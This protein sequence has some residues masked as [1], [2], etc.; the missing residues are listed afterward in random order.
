MNVAQTLRALPTETEMKARVCN[1]CL[2]TED[3]PEFETRCPGTKKRESI[4]FAR[5]FLGKGPSIGHLRYPFRSSRDWL[6]GRRMLGRK[7]LR[8]SKS[9]H[10][11]RNRSD[12][13]GRKDSRIATRRDPEK[14]ASQAMNSIHFKPN[15]PQVL[16]LKETSGICDE[17]QVLYEISDGRVLSL[18]PARRR[19]AERNSIRHR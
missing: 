17:F 8:L 19:Q 15:E 10:L 6:F 3:H 16:A 11:S 7:L 5:E 9:H 2:L 1:Q 12:S 18:P 4:A 14:E 13:Q